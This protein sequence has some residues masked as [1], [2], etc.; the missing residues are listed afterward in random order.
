MFDLLLLTGVVGSFL[1]NLPGR[2]D[3]DE[4]F[5]RYF[6]ALILILS[7]FIAPKREIKSVPLGVFL[8]IALASVFASYRVPVIGVFKEV[9]LGLLAVK[10]I[11]E[12]TTIRSYE[13]GLPLTVFWLFFNVLLLAQGF[14]S[15]L[16]GW[17]LA[18]TFV[19]PWMMGSAACLSIPFVKKWKKEWCLMLL[20]AVLL[21]HST[22]CFAIALL[23]Y[24]YPI[25]FTQRKLYVTL[26]SLGALLV[27]YVL[28]F[29]FSF[30]LT[31]FQ[32]MFNSFPHC[33]NWITGNGIGSW[34][35]MAFYRMNGITPTH[36][37]TAHNLYYQVFFEMG[38]LGLL[39]LL[40]VL[41]A[42]WV[43][44][45]G[46]CR[47]ALLGVLM[48]N[49]VHPVAHFPRFSVFLVILTAMILKDDGLKEVPDA[50]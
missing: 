9:L 39:A 5:V 48:L 10:V 21:S 16:K 11:A 1:V 31:R 45:Y 4:L 14:G 35:H 26:A 19:M 30:E 40:A 22:A 47:T 50:H 28:I 34:L 46:S 49:L 42:L 37:T 32:V 8:L 44:S 18:G 3:G 33:H 2:M 20:P 13:L 23:M 36:W 17:E 41:L 43:K 7:F 24:V 29:D 12:R 38:I 6:L 27:A 15:V 25:K